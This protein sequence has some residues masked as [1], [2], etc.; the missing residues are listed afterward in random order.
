MKA[1]Q[2]PSRY[3]TAQ[4]TAILLC[5][6]GWISSPMPAR[7]QGFQLKNFNREAGIDAPVLDGSGGALWGPQ[8]RVE[9]YGGRTPD[10]LNPTGNPLLGFRR[11]II[12]LWRPG[13][14]R[15]SEGVTPLGVNIG[16]WAWL[17]VRVWNADLGATYE[18]AV[19]AG[20]GG[21]GESPPFYALGSPAEGLVPPAPLRGLESF[22]VRQIIPEPSTWA[23]LT[24]GGLGLWWAR[25]GTVMEPTH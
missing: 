19:V 14:F 13:Y 25:R 2:G 9:L 6:G 17:Q 15:S 3:W 4:T 16:D 1:I 7:A 22:A 24:I 8:W 20:L 11:E 5:L 18:E 23:L 12:S 10:S 21:Y